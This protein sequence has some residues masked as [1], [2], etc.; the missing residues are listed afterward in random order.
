M[1]FI[2]DYRILC[3]VTFIYSCHTV[4]ADIFYYI[5]KITANKVSTVIFPL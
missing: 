4:K 5:I 1:L 3:A 2:T